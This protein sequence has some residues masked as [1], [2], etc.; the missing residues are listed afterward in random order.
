[1]TKIDWS[2]VPRTFDVGLDQG[3]LYVGSS[4]GVPWVGLVSVTDTRSVSEYKAAFQEGS[5]YSQKVEPKD[6]V[7]SLS[8]FTYPEEFEKCDGYRELST[9]FLIDHQDP[10]EFG[11]CYRTKIAN[12]IQGSD[13]GYK[14][15]FVYNALAKSSDVVNNSI[16]SQ[17]SLSAMSWSIETRPILVDGFKPSAHFVVNM[18]KVRAKLIAE[19]EALVYGSST[20]VP[21][22]P[23]PN[24]LFEILKYNSNPNDLNLFTS[25]FGAFF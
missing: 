23:S 5:K 6:H 25:D 19:V 22:L 2:S 18:S 21:R 4:P 17:L 16:G 11:L 12:E 20:T 14:L 7:L 8:A 3:V 15:H 10:V 13:Y 24:E 9:G 1:M